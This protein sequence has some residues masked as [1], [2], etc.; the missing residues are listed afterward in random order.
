MENLTFFVYYVWQVAYE[1]KIFRNLK[2]YI[3]STVN[4]SSNKCLLRFLLM[5]SYLEISH[6]QTPK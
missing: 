2:D 1:T 5:T 4:I 6:T 3:Y